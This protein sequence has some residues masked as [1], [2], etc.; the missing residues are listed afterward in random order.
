MIVLDA[1][2]ALE[3]L[4]RPGAWPELESLFDDAS[5]PVFAPHLLDV[6]VAQVLRRLVLRR[7][8]GLAQ[9][10]MAV[11]ALGALPVERVSHTPL[12]DRIWS[13]KDNLT[14]YDAT[15]VALAE[16]LDATLLTRDEHIAM[17]PRHRARI[18]VIK[19]SPL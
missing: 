4:L 9:A 11:A 2:A 3:L 8:A 13:L 18:R 16:F 17:A 1:S 5:V 6:E 15:Y 14:A 19:R 10:D 7:E 12:L